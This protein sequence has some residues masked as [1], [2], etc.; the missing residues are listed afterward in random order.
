MSGIDQ[1]HNIVIQ[2][3]SVE[4][5]N[6]YNDQEHNIIKSDNSETSHPCMQCDK[7]FI[8]KCELQK[9]ILSHTREKPFKFRLDSPK[10]CDNIDEEHNSDIQRDSVAEKT[11]P[12]IDQKHNIIE[13]DIVKAPYSCMHCDK[14]FLEK[15]KLQRHILSHT[16]EKPFK[17]SQCDKPFTQ[18]CN[19]N[20]HLRVHTGY[21]AFTCSQCNKTFAL[22]SNYDSHIITHTHL[23]RNIK[24][25]RVTLLRHLI[26]A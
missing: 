24:L 26:D 19:L 23:I 25:L 5:P 16:G 14:S 7:S 6:L 9:H 17:C 11:N 4:R 13:S 2:S 21:N 18:K 10:T 20:R 3:D 8:Q 1:E 22:K 12:C 15:S